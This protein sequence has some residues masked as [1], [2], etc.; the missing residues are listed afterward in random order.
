MRLAE[1]RIQG[2]FKVL[3]GKFQGFQ[4][5]F[6]KEIH[7]FTLYQQGSNSFF[8]SENWKYRNISIKTL[9]KMLLSRSLKWSQKGIKNSTHQPNSRKVY[10]INLMSFFSR[11]SD[12]KR[13]YMSFA[14][15]AR[16]ENF[17]I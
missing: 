3:K 1:L 13:L 2:H 7:Q 8:K 5:R 6:R 9:E 11:R 12:L 10:L 17:G 15:F 4:G 14:P 16:R